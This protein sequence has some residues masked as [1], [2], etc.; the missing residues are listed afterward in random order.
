MAATLDASSSCHQRRNFNKGLYALSD[1]QLYQFSVYELLVGRYK[2]LFKK[3]GTG[4][5]AEMT[6][7]K[8][9]LR[10]SLW[11]TQW[12]Y[13]DRNIKKLQAI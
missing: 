13:E 1:L 5:G 7:L 10:T 2:I 4:T 6:V 9:Y 12:G 11:L 8:S 3:Q